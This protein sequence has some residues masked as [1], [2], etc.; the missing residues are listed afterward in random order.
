VIRHAPI[1]LEAAGIEFINDDAPE[2]RLRRL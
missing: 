2:V 1:G